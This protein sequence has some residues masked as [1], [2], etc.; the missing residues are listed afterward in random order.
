MPSISTDSWIIDFTRRSYKEEILKRG[1]EPHKRSL[2]FILRLS[3][4]KWQVTVTFHGK[5]QSAR[6]ATTF[7][8][9]AKRREDLKNV[10]FCIDFGRIPLLD[11]T[12]TELIVS[13]NRGAQARRLWLKTLPDTESEYAAIADCLRLHV[14]E[15]PFRVRFPLYYGDGS[16]PT[17][18]LSGIIKQQELSAGVHVALIDGD[19]KPYIYKEVDRPLYQPRDTEVLEQ[20]LRNL[21][22]LRGSESVVRLISAVVSKNPYQTAETDDDDRPIV[23]RGILLEHHPNGTLQDGLQAPN[24]KMDWPLGRW[25]LQITSALFHL[26]HKGVTHMDLKP[27]NIVIS[28][29]CNAMLIDI[30]GVGGVTQEWLAPEM[31][32]IRDPLSQSMVSRKQNDIWALGKILSMMASVSCNDME[33]QLLRSVA[34]DATTEAPC[35]RISLRDAISKLSRFS[36]GWFLIK[37]HPSQPHRGQTRRLCDHLDGI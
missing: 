32:S 27:S 9:V 21:E 18:D 33:K 36:L 7:A 2:K 15:D 4:S 31:R 23:L 25:G 14:R 37:T 24:P 10:C 11:D 1:T 35:S 34:L 20:E 16:T 19:E 26:H 30:S 22:L 6:T 5:L 3:R 8:K 28:T 13:C 29:D 17:K 12:V